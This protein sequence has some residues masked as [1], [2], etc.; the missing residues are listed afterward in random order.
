MSLR[1]LTTSY[2]TGQDIDERI[3]EGEHVCLSC[4]WL[5]GCP[6]VVSS[7]DVTD[8]LLLSMEGVRGGGDVVT[9]LLTS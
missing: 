5:L 6:L 9:R 2:G 8:L 4:V 7:G 1:Y 3:V